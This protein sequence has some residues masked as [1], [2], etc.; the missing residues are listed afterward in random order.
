MLLRFTVE[1]HRSIRDAQDLLLTASQ[2]IKP[3]D[4][5]GAV[6]PVSGTQEQEAVLP[7]VALY[8]G[9]ASGKSNVIGAL[10]SMSFL[11][12]KSHAERGPVSPLPQQPF[13]LDHNS[14]TKPTRLEC[15]FTLSHAKELSSNGT[16]TEVQPVYTYGFKYT[17]KEICEE[18]LYQEG[19]EAEQDNQLL[20]RRTTLNQEVI[21]KVGGQLSGENESIRK[22]TRPNSLFLSAAA[23][24]NHSQLLGIYEYFS[25]MM[26]VNNPE[27]FIGVR[28]HSIASLVEKCRNKG[29]LKE[30]L[31]QADFGINDVTVKEIEL[32]EDQVEMMRKMSSISSERSTFED[33][34]TSSIP[35]HMKRLGFMHSTAD[36]ESRVLPYWLESR[37]TQTFLALLLPALEE[38]SEGSFLVIDELDTSLHPDLCRAFLSLFH[39]KISNPHGAQLLFSTHDVTLLDS[40]VLQRDEVWFTEKD[41]DGASQLTPLTDFK[42]PPPDQLQHG[43]I[44]QAYRRGSFGGVPGTR[45]FLVEPDAD[46]GKEE[47]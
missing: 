30:I 35:T 28:E 32:S 13:L 42:L 45:E 39:S 7:A 23:Q 20:F 40:D 25:R 2:R 37:G 46:Q 24:N 9:N 26:I 12:V 22:L 18:W 41:S 31:K 14:P 34:T 16:S 5:R 38:L 8:G 4:R 10:A 6:F 33:K 1:N 43:D 11:I 27:S 36:G 19:A 17:K 29:K 47:K 15:T 44:E 21:L 3:E